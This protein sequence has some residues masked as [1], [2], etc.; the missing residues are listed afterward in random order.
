MILPHSCRWVNLRLLISVLFN[1][2]LIVIVYTT[3]TMYILCL[4]E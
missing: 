2:H 3:Y 4:N 1:R